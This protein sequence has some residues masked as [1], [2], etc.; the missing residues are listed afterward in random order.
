MEIIKFLRH[1]WPLNYTKAS[2]PRSDTQ[3]NHKGATEH[4][5]FIDEW[6]AREVSLGRICGPFSSPPLPNFVVSPLNTVP[7][8]DSDERRVI[9]DLSWPHGQSVNDGIDVDTYLGKP[10]N[11]RFPTVDNICSMIKTLG[12][13][14]VIYKRDLKAA[15]RQFKVDPGDYNLLGYLWNGLFYYDNV[16]CMGQHTTANGFQRSKKPVTFIDSS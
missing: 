4:K 3:R 13:N 7:K 12:H 10:T 15:Y 16:L 8:P 2:L 14:C 11:L 9:V 5:Q 1:G 6:L